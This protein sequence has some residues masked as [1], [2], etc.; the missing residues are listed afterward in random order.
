[1]TIRKV[2][3]WLHLV[4]A[5]TI[6]S[7]VLMMS[8][9]GV[10]LTYESQIN[11]WDLREFRTSPSV[12]T[13]TALPIDTILGSVAE[14]DH[15]LEVSAITIRSDAYEPATINVGGGLLLLADQ[16][17]GEVMGN[18]DRPIRQALRTIMY[19]HRWFALEGDN[20]VIG[21][22]I[23][24]VS[25]LAF[26]F[27]IISGVYLW[28]PKSYSKNTL[29]RIVWF[30]SGLRGKAKNFNW[31]NVIGIWT[32][33]PLIVIVISGSVISY[34][35]ASDAVYYLVGES[36]PARSSSSNTT[37]V[38]KTAPTIDE[39]QDP[40]SY[41]QIFDRAA[42]DA[43]NW[44]SITIRIPQGDSERVVALVDRGSG[45]QPS[46]Q[47]ELVFDRDTGELTERSGYPTY[48][49]GRK[50]RRWLRFAHT[51]E[52]F[53]LAGQTLAGIVTLGTI[54]LVWTG[55][56]MTWRRFINAI[57]AKGRHPG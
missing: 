8:V 18:N 52:V 47:F 29:R 12:D 17:S 7:V 36:P 55:L 43:I 38:E 20:R 31:H 13:S 5:I 33:L 56:A 4:V 15:T 40:V 23:T 28:L 21:R 45:R 25:N 22:T 32:V 41:Q 48:S 24:A 14:F 50:I 37:T 3:F 57:R 1:M 51:G 2:V 54:I 42:D 35:W 19:W 46:K 53:G 11:K 39:I 10:L 44:R 16:Y 9:T 49:Q 26:L 34:R 6:S 30:Q 27:L